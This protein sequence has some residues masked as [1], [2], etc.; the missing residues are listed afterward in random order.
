M[1]ET[2]KIIN[3]VYQCFATKK[4]RTDDN[5]TT[6]QAKM[7]KD[8]EQWKITIVKEMNTLKELKCGIE[9]QRSEVERNIQVIPTK[10]HLIKKYDSMGNFIKFKAR[11]VVM[12][13]LA[14]HLNP[15]RKH[16]N[17]Y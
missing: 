9:V 2:L 13:N 8:W 16:L 5:P 1:Q 14:K 3:P 7:S 15:K 10:F 6:R 11:L 4:E 17:C 12:G